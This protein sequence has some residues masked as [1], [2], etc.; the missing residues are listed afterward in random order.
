MSK[1][2]KKNLQKKNPTLTSLILY[3]FVLLFFRSS[4]SFR[5]SLLFL[6]FC[7]T[8]IEECKLSGDPSVVFS[9]DAMLAFGNEQKLLMIV[10]LRRLGI[11]FTALRHYEEAMLYAVLSLDLARTMPDPT[12]TKYEGANQLSCC[13][14]VG[15]ISFHLR[16]FDRCA[17]FSA[18]LIGTLPSRNIRTFSVHGSSF[19][20]DDA[21]QAI[22]EALCEFSFVLFSLFSM[23]PGICF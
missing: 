6:L 8:C 9:Q 18:E 14:D 20:L 16:D 23:V 2:K 13:H 5:F 11:A 4:I 3:F 22:V 10:I 15:R 12:N 17:I 7:S 21:L 1:K 19:Y